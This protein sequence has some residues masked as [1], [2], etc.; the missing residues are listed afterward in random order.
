MKYT[1]ITL[2]AIITL[3]LVLIANACS[4]SSGDDDTALGRVT[5][6][7]SYRSQPLVKNG[8]APDFQFQMPDGTTLFLSDLLGQVV[9]LNFWA[10]NCPYCVVEMPYLQNAYDEL[11][12]DGV[13]ILGINTGESEK[14]VV[15][16][17]ARKKLTFPIILDPDVYV[18][19]LYG[20]KYL[21]TTYL[22]DKT[23]NI[24]SA[25]IGAFKNSNEIITTL[26]AL[27]Q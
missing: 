17:V 6:Y 23:G 21:P 26:K 7:R 20:V 22:I 19:A 24:Q 4:K 2:A 11:S 3:A 9:L 16:F 8:P 14:T 18:S 13:V 10:V 27:L 15:K 1:R 25:K 12:V 5:D